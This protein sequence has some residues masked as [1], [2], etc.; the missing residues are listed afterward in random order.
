MHNDG[1]HIDSKAKASYLSSFVQAVL[2]FF[3]SEGS[4]EFYGGEANE[5]DVMKIIKSA[6][7]NLKIFITFFYDYYLW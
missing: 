2:P 5:C 1:G 4:Q 6:I 7:P 3:K